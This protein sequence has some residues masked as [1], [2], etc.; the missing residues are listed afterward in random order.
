MGH[1]LK[2]INKRFI[3]SIFVHKK[4]LFSQ[5]DTLFLSETGTCILK[6]FERVRVVMV[7]NRI[8]YSKV[9]VTLLYSQTPRRRCDKNLIPT[10]KL[11]CERKR[12]KINWSMGLLV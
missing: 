12:K 5:Q 7:V 1:V 8:F 11:L 6:C 10:V 2:V 4:L 9:K 3:L